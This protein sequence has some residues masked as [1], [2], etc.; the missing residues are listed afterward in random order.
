MIKNTISGKQY[1]GISSAHT[2]SHIPGLILLT[3]AIIGKKIIFVISS[4]NE[5]ESDNKLMLL[6][7]LVVTHFKL[8][9]L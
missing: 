7:S 6:A 1:T 4:I 9:M 5:L 3:V 2:H 8:V